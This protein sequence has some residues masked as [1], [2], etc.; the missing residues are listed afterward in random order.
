MIASV[1]LRSGANYDTLWRFT[2]DYDSSQGRSDAAIVP[3]FP[4]TSASWPNRHAGQ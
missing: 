3:K 4:S 1:A 2:M